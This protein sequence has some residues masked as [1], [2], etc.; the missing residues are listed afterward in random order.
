MSS[1]IC[2]CNVYIKVCHFNWFIT[3]IVSLIR[4]LLFK[5]DVFL[6]TPQNLN[7]TITTQLINT[8][9]DKYC[10]IEIFYSLHTR[11]RESPHSFSQSQL[12]K[13]AISFLSNPVRVMEG[14]QAHPHRRSVRGDLQ[15]TTAILMHNKSAIHSYI[16]ASEFNGSK[17]R[18]QTNRCFIKIYIYLKTV[19]LWSDC[20][21]LPTDANKFY[22]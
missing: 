11:S 16:C 12:T 13:A 17:M 22:I 10:E 21:S 4:F 14:C 19:C 20:F 2:G 9:V 18:S 1:R 5:Q 15:F 3:K 7:C 6:W 8:I